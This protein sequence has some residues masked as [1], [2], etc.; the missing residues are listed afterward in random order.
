MAPFVEGEDE[1]ARHRKETYC[2]AQIDLGRTKQEIIEC[3]RRRDEVREWPL[4][5][6]TRATGHP[7]FPPAETRPHLQKVGEESSAAWKG[8]LYIEGRERENPLCC[9][10][11]EKKWE[12]LEKNEGEG[13]IEQ[14]KIGEPRRSVWADKAARTR[15]KI[16]AALSPLPVLV[17]LFK[18]NTPASGR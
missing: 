15:D 8:G 1:E 9:R 3:W 2:V 14:R 11:V 17:S 10:R 16:N 18:K 12:W 13:R 6:I 4:D 5:L 7:L